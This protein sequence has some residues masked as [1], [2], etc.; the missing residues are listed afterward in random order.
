MRTYLNRDWNFWF[1]QN[2]AECEKVDIP[3]TVKVT[4]FNSFDEGIYQTVCKYEKEIER[5]AELDGKAVILHFDGAGHRATIY[6]NHNELYT[7]KCGYT[8]FDVD[9]TDELKKAEGSTFVLTV[10]LDTRETLDQ[11]PFGNVIDYMT[12]GGLYREVWMEVR[13][14]VYIKSTYHRYCSDKKLEN[15][16]VIAGIEEGEVDI[17]LTVLRDDGT[18]A[19]EYSDSLKTGKDLEGTFVSGTFDLKDVKEWNPDTPVLYTVKTELLKDGAV[20][21]TYSVLTG[22]RT[23]EFRRDGFFCNGRKLKLRGVN[24]HQSYAYT[25]YAMPDSVQREDARILRDELG[26]NAVRTSHYPQ[27]HAFIEECDRLGLFVFTEIPGWQFVGGDE[28][29]AQAVRNTEDMIIGYRNHPSIILWGVRINESMDDDEL[30]TKTNDVAHRFAPGIVTGGVRFIKKS[31]LLED[32]YTFN[33]FIYNGKTKPTTAK[34]DVTPDMS[35]PFLISE[36]NGHMYP[37][38]PFDDESH[39]IEHAI[40][41]AT[42][43]NDVYGHDETLGSFAWCMFDY[44]THKDF[45]SGDRICYHGITDMFRNPKLA[46]Y[47]Y[48][49]QSN[50]ETVMEVASDFNIGEYPASTLNKIWVFTNADSVKFYKN[51]YFL[52]EFFPD[53][54]TFPNLPHPPIRINDFIGDKLMTEEGYSPQVSARIKKLMELVADYGLDD[55]PLKGKLLMARM[56]AFDHMT[57]SKGYDLYSKYIGG[58]GD[59]VKVYEFVA[60]KDGKEV[61]RLTKSPT[62]SLHLEVKADK[63]VLTE[64]KTYDVAAIR[65]SARNQNGSVETYACDPVVLKTEGPI[66]VIGPE[67]A[68]L[69]G[70]M[71]GTYIRSTGKGN[72]KL[73]LTYRGVDTTVEFE[74]R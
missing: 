35:K 27:S 69:R 23:V 47:V 61:A 39:R 15:K 56:M 54:E 3:H 57:I 72:G 51:G 25:G 63:T 43:L 58:W 45:G 31:S 34:K 6:V 4:D 28:W 64:D 9:I 26:M 62:E 29:K 13:N 22:F 36:Y 73:T 20:I 24:R 70:G 17:K 48:K 49:S 18:T 66:E 11:P 65:F 12:Y 10:I 5:P 14:E 74:V 38:K 21:D 53:R 55:L 41:H 33:D 7:H 19:C 42:V 52:N 30:Y 1:D 2:K 40:R 50:R 60:I 16:I 59:K 71:S 37:T 8:A 44:N 46:A 68:T 32:V 67:I